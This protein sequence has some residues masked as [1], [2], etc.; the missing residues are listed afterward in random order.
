M[1]SPEIVMLSV[2]ITPWTKPTS[3]H[4]RDQRRLGGDDRLEQ[5]EVG[6][7][8][9]GGRGVVARDRVVGEAPEQVEVVGGPGVLEGADAQVAARHPGQH[10]AG[11]HGLA[12]HGATGRHD[13][14][15]AGRGDAEG[16][17]R[18]A[19]DVL[20]QHRADSGQAVAAAGERRTPRALEVQVAEPAVAS[21]TS[22]P[23]SRARP[24]P[25]RGE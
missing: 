9:V 1:V 11:Q 20:A 25:S 13:G 5:G 21:S 22:S 23:S 8:R 3:I 18:L 19:D 16:V 12:L 17:H 15:A 4:S 2:F 14:E 6:V 10:G 24:S 7:L